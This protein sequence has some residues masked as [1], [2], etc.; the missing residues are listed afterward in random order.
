MTGHRTG[1]QNADDL[2]EAAVW[3]ARL[4]GPV[5]DQDQAAFERWYASDPAHAAAY[6]RVLVGWE[7]AGRLAATG[8]DPA[9][10]P[11]SHPRMNRS[12]IAL[13]A[14]AAAI[15]LIVLGGVGLHALGTFGS[16]AGGNTQLAS[17][18]GEIRS[19]KL[20]DG[21]RVTLDTDSQIRV[22]YSGI[23]RSIVLV[24][25]RARFEV[26]HNPNR[27]F[28]VK[29]AET[30][31]IAHGTI[32]D[33]ALGDHRVAVALLR[34][35]VEVRRDADAANPHDAGVRQLLTP[36]Q[37][38]ALGQDEPVAAVQPLHPADTRWV[39]GMLAFDR[40]RLADVVA[41]ANRY[42]ANRIVLTDAVT[43]DLRFT[44]TV[45]AADPAALARLLAATFHLRLAQNGHGDIILSSSELPTVNK[46]P[47]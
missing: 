25:G 46:N 22:A 21:S 47:G 13:L 7:T 29:A 35:S 12:R 37:T 14:A 31:V 30:S 42:A 19:E 5:N 32:F 38:L 33:V 34:G 15:V 17:R 39:S 9:A 16:H 10:T 2:D 20:P 6:D 40:A 3:L 24:R 11:K 8:A 44:G 36:G 45:R 23:V 18:V 43:R 26:A 1:S 28:I 27:P 41:V 4:R